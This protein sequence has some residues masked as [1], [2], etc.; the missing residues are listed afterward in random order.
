MPITASVWLQL[1]SLKRRLRLQLSRL[2][3]QN[4]IRRCG[5]TMPNWVCRRSWRTRELRQRRLRL[6]VSLIRC[7][8]WFAS[9]RIWRHYV[10]LSSGVTLVQC[11]MARKLSMISVQTSV[12][13]TCWILLVTLL[14]PSWLGWRRMNQ[15][16]TVRFIRSCCLVTIS[17][18]VSVEL[19]IQR[20]ADSLRVCSGTSRI[21][22]WL[23]SWWSIMA[24][25]LLWLLTLFLPS[26]S[27]V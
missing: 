6:L 18:C 15:S 7:M 11:P 1:S 13:H 4:R 26:Q 25:I 10:L 22:R 12:W 27:R 21:I 8:D 14:P 24:S 9:I 5:G 17:P 19:W 3:G 16:F 23:T 20:S 2:V